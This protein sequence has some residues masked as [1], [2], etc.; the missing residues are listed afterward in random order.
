MQTNT[1]VTLAGCEHSVTQVFCSALPVSYGQPPA[2][3]WE[4]LARLVLGAS[5]EATLLAA[6]LNAARSGNATVYLTLVGGGAFGNPF[7]WLAESILAAIAK[8]PNLGLDIK[9]VSYQRPDEG[10]SGMLTQLR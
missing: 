2:H 6:A 1:Q 4:Q 10:I 9:F 7:A 5:Y 8:N 3:L